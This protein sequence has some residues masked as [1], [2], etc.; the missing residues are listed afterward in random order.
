[1]SGPRYPSPADMK[2]LRSMALVVAELG[3]DVDVEH[4]RDMDPKSTAYKLLRR[5]TEE[6]IYR[7]LPWMLKRV[8]EGW[9]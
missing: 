9:Q 4:L 3:R 2:R 7:D 1:M 8:V 5:W 6:L